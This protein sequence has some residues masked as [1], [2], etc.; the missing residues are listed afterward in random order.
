MP[1]IYTYLAIKIHADPSVIPTN[2]GRN[3]GRVFYDPIAQ[4]TL[5]AA[6]CE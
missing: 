4:R 3:P 5:E 6:I 2:K 1:S